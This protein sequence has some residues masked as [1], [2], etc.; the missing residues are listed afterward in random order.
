MNNTLVGGAGTTREHSLYAC[1]LD[2]PIDKISLVMRRCD[3][4]LFEGKCLS[5]FFRNSHR[6]DRSVNTENDEGYPSNYSPRPGGASKR[7][8]SMGLLRGSRQ[9]IKTTQVASDRSDE[10]F[11]SSFLSSFVS[12]ARRES[13]RNEDSLHSLATLFLVRSERVGGLVTPTFFSCRVKVSEVSQT[14]ARSFPTFFA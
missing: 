6:L 9:K 2:A 14:F 7:E 3:N 13:V 4:K 12:Q 11:P 5:S 1:S 8:K 10:Q